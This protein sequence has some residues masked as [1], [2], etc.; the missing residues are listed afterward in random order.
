MNENQQNQTANDQPQ[1]KS[2]FDQFKGIGFIGYL[3]IAVIVKGI[4]AVVGII[5][6]RNK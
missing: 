5:A 2:F 1:K 4:V 6:N 3:C